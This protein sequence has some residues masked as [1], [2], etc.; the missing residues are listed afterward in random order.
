MQ[1]RLI[2]ATVF[3]VLGCSS[4]AMTAEELQNKKMKEEVALM[5]ERVRDQ[6]SDSFSTVLYN[7]LP[8]APKGWAFVVG[9][10][11]FRAELSPLAFDSKLPYTVTPKPRPRDATIRVYA[12]QSTEEQDLIEFRWIANDRPLRWLVSRNVHVLEVPLTVTFKD[13]SV[14]TPN[15]E[16]L[17]KYVD[18]LLVLEGADDSEGFGPYTIRLPWP[19]DLK[20]GETFS[21]NSKVAPW[22]LR[23][24]QDR[25]DAIIRNDKLLILTYHRPNQLAGFQNGAQWFPKEFREQVRKVASETKKAKANQSG[26]AGSTDQ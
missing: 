19:A 4:F 14:P 1:H 17:K 11:F 23:R 24:W 20:P 8:Q 2:I 13:G 26:T 12:A 22:E 10:C 15:V 9:A 5:L 6:P 3:A 7:D 21:S 25:I 16:S 18:S